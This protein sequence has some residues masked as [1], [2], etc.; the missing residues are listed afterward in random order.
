MRL[1][2][3]ASPFGSAGGAEDSGS[4]LAAAGA[5]AGAAGSAACEIVDATEMHS[6]IAQ[7]DNL[8]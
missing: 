7:I 6:A 5:D 4:A 8:Q 3:R 2:C 1:N